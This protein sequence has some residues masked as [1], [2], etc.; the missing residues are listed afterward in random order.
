M[1][2]CFSESSIIGY[3]STFA[4][5]T[6]YQIV[7]SGSKSGNLYLDVNCT[8]TVRIYATNATATLAWY[9]YL[10]G[11]PIAAIG[12]GDF[13]DTTIYVNT[14]STIQVQYSSGVPVPPSSLNATFYDLGASTP[15]I[16]PSP[17]CTPTSTPTPSGTQPT[18]S[19]TMSPTTT[20]TPSP[21]GVFCLPIWLN[22]ATMLVYTP[23]AGNTGWDITNVQYYN[24]DTPFPRFI[25]FN[26]NCSGILY[27]EFYSGFYYMTG[28]YT[29]VANGVANN[30]P[31]ALAS[32]IVYKQF[33][34]VSG[35]YVSLQLTQPLLTVP[36]DSLYFRVYLVPNT[37]SPTPTATA[38][39][40]PTLSAT[41]TATPSPTLSPTSTPTNSPTGSPTPTPTSTDPTPS[42]THTA[43]PTPSPA[44][45]NPTPSP[46]L[47]ASPTPTT[48]ASATATPTPTA[49]PN[50][51]GCATI[52]STRNII[53]TIRGANTGYNINVSSFT[54]DYAEL[55]ID[56]TCEVNVNVYLAPLFTGI[57]CQV[58]YRQASSGLTFSGTFESGSP[59][60]LTNTTFYN[61]GY[62]A[63]RIPQSGSASVPSG[64]ALGYI[65]LSGP[66]TPTPTM[67][68][69]ASPTKTPVA[70]PS[71]T[72]TP[73]AT[74]RGSPTF[75]TTPQPTP[76]PL[77]AYLWSFGY[78][79]WGQL[80]NN[81]GASSANPVQ[82]VF[83]TASWRSVCISHSDSN[84]GI[85]N[86]GTF[87]VWGR[88]SYGSLGLGN[89]V[90]VSTP[91][92]VLLGGTDWVQSAAN[93]Y[94][95]V[96][97]KT[98]GSL[99]TCGQNSYGQLGNN[100]TTN[101]TLFVKVKSGKLWK[102]AVA[103]KQAFFAIATDNTLWACGKNS[104][105]QI[106]NSAPSSV[107]FSSVVQI[108]L[109]YNW[110]SVDSDNNSVVAIREDNTLWCWGSNSAGQLGQ[111]FGPLQIP[112]TSSP[113][114]V[115]SGGFNWIKC[116]TGYGSVYAIK[117]DGSLWCWGLNNTGQLGDLTTVSRSSPVQTFGVALNPW[118]SVQA[119]VQHAT[120]LQSD[121]SLYSWGR[122]DRSQLGNVGTT[123]NVSQPT[124]V[125]TP[126]LTWKSVSGGFSSTTML[127]ENT[128]PPS[129]TVTGTPTDTPTVTASPTPTPTPSGTEPTPTPTITPVY[130]YALYN[131]GSAQQ[132]QIG[133]NQNNLIERL[134]VQTAITGPVWQNV[135]CGISMGGGIK[136]DYSLWV[137]GGNYYGN[138]G[139]PSTN[140]IRVSSPVQIF[141]GGSWKTAS[142]GFSS[143]G[144]K[145]DNS[146]YAWGLNTN[147][148]L[149]DGTTVDKDRPTFIGT[150]Y[151]QVSTSIGFSAA[152]TTSNKLFLWGDNSYGAVG[153]N[154]TTSYSSPVQEI[155]NSDWRKVDVCDS[156]NGPFVGAIK[157]DN[158]LWAWGANGVGQLGQ[159]NL[160]SLSSPSQIGSDTWTDVA[161]GY[162]FMAAIKSDGSMWGW[163][164]NNF[165]QLG[166]DNTDNQ[167]SPVQNLTGTTNWLTVS[168]GYYHVIATRSGSTQVWGWGDGSAGALGQDN[169]VTYSSP[170]Q[171]SPVGGLWYSATAG[172]SNS[173]G[174]IDIVPSPT[175]SP[176][177]SPS[178]TPTTTA[179]PTPSS[180]DP[181]PT[182]TPSPSSTDPTP[183]PTTTPSPTP[184]TVLWMFGDNYF[185][186]LGNNT[187]VDSKPIIKT[188][189]AT[190]DWD[191]VNCAKGY[192]TFGIKYDGSLWSWGDNAYGQ[193]G[194]GT[195]ID[196][197]IPVQEISSSIWTKVQGGV[198]HTAA[199]KKDGTI[200]SWGGN[201]YGDL[202]IN[203]G[204]ANV[205]SI[206]SPV[207]EFTNSTWTDLA[208]GFDFTSAIKT[209]GT[210][211]TW[212]SNKYCQ[213]GDGRDPLIYPAQS[214]PTQEFY[215]AISWKSVYATAFSTAALKVDGSLWCWGNGY[216]GVLGNNSNQVWSFPQPVD[217]F[218]L[219]YSWIQV[220]GGFNHMAAIRSDYTLWTWGRNNA[221]QLG[222]GTVI[223]RSSPVLVMG[224]NSWS[225]VSAGY[226]FTVAIDYFGRLWSWGENTNYSLG[227]IPFSVNVSSPTQIDTGSL[228]WGFVSAGYYSVGLLTGDPDP[229]PSPTASPSP[230]PTLSI[231][232]T[233]S[234]TSTPSPTPT[235]LPMPPFVT[236][237]GNL[238]L[239]GD[240]TYGQLGD[241]TVISKSSIIQTIS[242]GTDW[243]NFSLTFTNAGAV[244]DD[245]TLWCWG[246]NTFG[247]LGD[248]SV[249]G[250]SSPQQTISSTTDWFSVSTG[251]FCTFALKQNGTLWG[252]GLNA[253]GKLG[254]STT[255]NKSSPIQVMDTY[256]YGWQSVSAGYDHT[257]AVS[258]D[259]T[260]WSW[261]HNS[262]GELGNNSVENSSSPVQTSIAGV[263][264][265]QVT[266]GKHTT[267][268]LKKDGSIWAWGNNLLGEFGNLTVQNSS[269]PVLVGAGQKFWTYISGGNNFVA[270]LSLEL[271]PTPSPTPTT[272]ESPTP[273][274]T[275]TPSS[276]QPTPTPTGTQPTPSPTTTAT[277]T[278]TPVPTGTPTATASPTATQQPTPTPTIDP[279]RQN[280]L[281]IYYRIY[282]VFKTGLDLYYQLGG[283]VTWS[284]RV[285][286]ECRPLVQPLAPFTDD[287]QKCPSRTI[288]TIFANSVTDCC[289][290]INEM[291]YITKVKSIQRYSKPVYSIEEDYLIAQGNYN[292]AVVEWIPESFCQYPTC[293]DLC[294]D[295]I[296]QQNVN[297]QMQYYPPGSI[298]V[299]YGNIKISGSARVTT[300]AVTSVGLL[301]V[302][303]KAGVSTGG[304]IIFTY[305]YTGSGMIS[306]SGSATS[307]EPSVIGIL[308]NVGSSETVESLRQETIIYV[309]PNEVVPA[310]TIPT[311]LQNIN[312]CQCRNIPLQLLLNTNLEVPSNF[313]NFI[314][315]NN[316]IFNPNLYV[317]YNSLT[318]AYTNSYVYVSPYENEKWTIIVNINCNNDLDNFDVEPIWTVTLMF[319]RYL[320]DGLKLDSILEIWMPASQFCPVGSGRTIGSVIAVDVISNPPVCV[321][322]N[323]TVIENVFLNDGAGVFKSQSWN[324]T[325]IFNMQISPANS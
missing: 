176:S 234:P 226:N 240:N 269:N 104:Y 260:L 46:T 282:S 7:N 18:P 225:Y 283:L 311:G 184:E 202:G 85:K 169:Y 108:G 190:P 83:A 194:T 209:N 24:Y 69:S 276:T 126:G 115:V 304:D 248:N 294:V 133:N 293:S 21:T 289:R 45:T 40:T 168:C 1:P 298:I 80:G 222:D 113:V 278:A 211:W 195:I 296:L 207:Q 147:G 159:N 167:S 55:I 310:I 290:Q 323:N 215:S 68:P 320:P 171:V 178:P 284:Y 56:F 216:Y 235:A 258:L 245:G 67:S 3:T 107:N 230:T 99:W 70:S 272:S 232:P 186:Q 47:S 13:L 243:N 158:T 281:D 76:T 255:V 315:R 229:T 199:I 200:W 220:A 33:N 117:D 97:I 179:S 262:Y 65:T 144:I 41:A 8:T 151:I 59:F 74:P 259:G 154:T 210:L 66:L 257:V 122:N 110:L 181:S 249:V 170:V 302:G 264:W 36:A 49:T 214:S 300:T 297:G 4:S 198:Y 140:G 321:V 75:T 256:P 212:G 119:G 42:P 17:T 266:S 191:Y 134:P 38:T 280:S 291:D 9:F 27:T 303:G 62:F 102:R 164:Q 219:N 63:I 98:D 273:T 95:T 152:I 136:T 123:Q 204:L 86:D 261:G 308:Q 54:L 153:D 149:G 61:G 78:N 267:I 82:T 132:G 241:E 279:A 166:V 201:S 165:G 130:G 109:G 44:P 112:S 233:P 254:D 292:P 5:D 237:G 12:A 231:S 77:A 121:G 79:Y 287:E 305:K 16:T 247:A 14:G 307:T 318:R 114:Q 91:T 22:T 90:N 299:G 275:P 242:G 322:N 143:L 206:S 51:F 101:S 129:A 88:N 217:T 172:G 306:I 137:Y 263:D 316:L 131:W 221:G 81:N 196:S 118:I 100:S 183:S 52:S 60:S 205:S 94:N 58:G 139:V 177:P 120:G 34:V 89:T 29:V 71:P 11:S 156:S 251:Y 87:W 286:T 197:S 208:A 295:Y 227:N 253:F 239:A 246:Q 324:I 244:K 10:N 277:P 161:C 228:T 155:T 203:L 193:L 138:L 48:T 185:G 145:L 20:P 111:N 270:G 73:S 309:E 72:P 252:W 128:P 192:Q 288:L 213:I 31:F 96:A 37:P 116:S 274:T 150:N 92:Q 23:L 148:Q 106:G 188:Y 162:N 2:S 103:G 26:V 224:V 238:Y 325:Q 174:L 28:S 142:L 163:G 223:T 189:Y 30:F 25:E 124:F 317:I 271:I 218:P 268:A 187:Q 93:V 15:T 50:P 301:V 64:S 125:N 135:F 173:A 32:G 313:T 285:E 84:C 53:T 160:I 39:P 157:T 182:P 312:L 6:E 319:R 265:V 105:G 175:P 180:T 314:N 43:S 146:L 57:T 19:P 127:T 35:D 236:V 250:A 141:G